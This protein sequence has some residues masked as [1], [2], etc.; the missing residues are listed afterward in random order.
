MNYIERINAAIED[1][2]NNDFQN[3]ELKLNNI[4]QD[5]QIKEIEDEKNTHYCFK[6][7]IE[8]LL[9]WNM[10]R[11]KKTNVIPDINY[12]QVYYYLGYIYVEKKDFEK[13]IEYLKTGL[14]WN[15]LDVRLMFEIAEVHLREGNLDKY[16]AQIEK[17]HQFIYSSVTLSEYLRRM[18]YYYSERRR[19]DIANALY[20]HSGYYHKTDIAENELKYI[21]QQEN[22]EL[23]VSTPDEVGKLLSEYNIPFAFDVAMT[24]V[25]ISEYEY[26]T[27]NKPDH[28]E[29]K[30]LSRTLYDITYEKQYM[31]YTTLK[32]EEL[33]VSIRIPETWKYM[34]K[35]A[36]EQHNISKNIAFL[37]LTTNNQ[38]ITISCEGKYAEE[39]L[40]EVYSSIINDMKSNGTEIVA[41]YSKND[42]KNIKQVFVDVKNG[43]QVLRIFNNFLIVNGYLFNASWSVVNNI[44]IGELYNRVSSSFAMDVVLSLEKLDVKPE[45]NIP[46]TIEE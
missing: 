42:G 38:N 21:A 7:Y 33:G 44:E 24:R 14:R 29:I 4:L 34:S 19:F 36:Y 9:F 40:E 23:R 11:P 13:A 5:A 3:A 15:P 45:E 20:T 43:E 27:K 28:S 30:T 22:R 6:N 26:L 37:L 41:E 8:A 17:T 35:E 39:Q 18:G 16:R 31:L 12:A 2:K 25:L 32:D 1:V 46:N 10:Y